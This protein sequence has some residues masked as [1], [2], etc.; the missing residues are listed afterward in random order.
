LKGNEH[1]QKLGG[2]GQSS[3]PNDWRREKRVGKIY[4]GTL[5]KPGKNRRCRRGKGKRKLTST[6]KQRHLGAWETKKKVGKI[7]QGG[8]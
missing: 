2:L 4:Q 3:S 5:F 8:Q 7:R 1:D 6:S